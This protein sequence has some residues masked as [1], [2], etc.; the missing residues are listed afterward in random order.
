[1][2]EL[3]I[4]L[5]I[6]EIIEENAKAENLDRISEIELEVG[7]SSGVVV[8]AL[9]FALEEAV[10]STVMEHAKIVFHEIPSILRCDSCN[11]EFEPE[12][13][14][15]PCPKCGHLYSDVIQGEEM[16]IRKIKQ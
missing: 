16:K 11:H 7:S 14:F 8:E 3:S 9:K 5:N 15:T 10:K 12:D 1:M 4:A 6:V 13:I 2:H